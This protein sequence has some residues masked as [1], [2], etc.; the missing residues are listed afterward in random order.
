MGEGNPGDPRG[1]TGLKKGR[2]VKAAG[3]AQADGGLDHIHKGATSANKKL[4]RKWGQS[5]GRGKARLVRRTAYNQ[6]GKGRRRTIC[7]KEKD[8]QKPYWKKRG[9]GKVNHSCAGRNG[10]EV[11][12]LREG[13]GTVRRQVRR[14]EAGRYR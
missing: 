6:G 14:I 10:G 2:K 11:T 5:R 9:G 12:D 3:G 1:G 4:A 7:G 13:G 8:V